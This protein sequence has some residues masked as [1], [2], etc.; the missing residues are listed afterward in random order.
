MKPRHYIIVEH[1]VIGHIAPD[2][3]HIADEIEG[4]PG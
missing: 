4:A 1:D 2:A 3:D